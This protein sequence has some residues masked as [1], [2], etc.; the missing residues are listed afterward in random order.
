MDYF[1]L[2]KDN[3]LRLKEEIRVSDVRRVGHKGE[4]VL[5]VF[6]ELSGTD[7]HIHFFHTNKKGKKVYRTTRDNIVIETRPKVEH[8]KSGVTTIGDVLDS[9]IIEKLMAIK[10][11]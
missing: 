1:E 4:R 8:S 6:E 2:D 7:S 10:G 9:K 5:V 3:V 11:T